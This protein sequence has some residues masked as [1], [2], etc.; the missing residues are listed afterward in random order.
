M[1]YECYK[2]NSSPW[3]T[4]SSNTNSPTT[5][6]M[7]PQCSAS[8]QPVSSSQTNFSTSPNKKQAHRTL[9]NLKCVL[10]SYQPRRRMCEKFDQAARCCFHLFVGREEKRKWCQFHFPFC[11]DQESLWVWWT[12]WKRGKHSSFILKEDLRLTADFSKMATV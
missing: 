2:S 1:C 6:S 4:P 10:K 3:E 7:S 12:E 5:A 8:V 11:L 9:N